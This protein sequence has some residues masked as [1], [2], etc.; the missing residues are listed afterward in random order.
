M[1]E[2]ITVYSTVDEFNVELAKIIVNQIIRKPESVIGLSTGRTTGE[3]HRIV[4]TMYLQQ[5]FDV[6][7]VTIFGLDE[8]VNVPREYHGSCYSMLKTEVVDTLGIKE[9]NFLML[10]T[11]SDD[12][13]R[14]C[15]NFRKEIERRGGIDVMMLGL[16][17][18]DH[19]GFNQPG[20]PFGSVAHISYMSEKL[21]ARI[22]KETATPDNIKFGGVTLGIKDIMHASR[23]VLMADGKNKAEAVRKMLR[24]PVTEDVP[25]SVLQLHPNC[26]FVFDKEA[27]SLL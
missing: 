19:L 8:V 26:E 24:G 20:T 6:S 13:T 22:R 17:E 1:S 5:R 18:N 2:N 15:E 23:I 12:Y 16:G 9:E 14:D 10:P 25:A 21:E 27:A 7:E 4:G 3:I 11:N